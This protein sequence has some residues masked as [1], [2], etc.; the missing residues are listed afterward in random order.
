MRLH[1][2]LPG[3]LGALIA[4][5][6]LPVAAIATAPVNDAR[7]AAMKFKVDP[8]TNGIRVLS[9][10]TDSVWETSRDEDV[11]D[12]DL[13]ADGP[14]TNAGSTCLKV[15]PDTAFRGRNTVWYHL[16]WPDGEGGLADDPGERM[17]IEL[18]TVEVNYANAIAVVRQTLGPAPTDVLAHCEAQNVSIG[19]L[20]RSTV[21][22][23]A[24][25]GFAY[26]VMVAA[27][28]LFDA[29]DATST[30]TLAVRAVDLVPP[31]FSLSA[32]PAFAEPGGRTT[33]EI[34]PPVDFGAGVDLDSLTWTARWANGVAIGAPV[35]DPGNRLVA[36]IRW[37]RGRIVPADGREA[38]VSASIRDR[39]GN[40]GTVTLSFLVKD[41]TAP[42]ASLGVTPITG[43]VK[44]TG[45]CSE[46]GGILRLSVQRQGASSTLRKK[47]F[48][49]VAAN[50]RRS[51]SVRLPRT[52]VWITRTYCKDRSGN[53]AQSTL[54]F[55]AG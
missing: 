33:F 20:S 18:T 55:F 51:I 29:P 30:A 14:A 17:A 21:S 31:S 23:V 45:R 46:V 5:A 44:V 53:A 26:D 9:D 22:F 35:P 25:P 54:G 19:S 11:T 43:G 50:R 37:P 52:A 3:L 41:R 49:E 24:Q 7:S 1:H 13:H 36:T 28:S 4:L 10:P 16:Q 6:V 42:R 47:A 48:F 12:P 38:T 8:T 40:R 32:R 39:A 2:R 34:A 15:G 27:V